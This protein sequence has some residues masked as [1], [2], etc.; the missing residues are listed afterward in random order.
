MCICMCEHC[1]QTTQRT[2]QKLLTNVQGTE[3]ILKEQ[4][5]IQNHSVQV[6]FVAKYS[7]GWSTTVQT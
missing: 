3:L 7:S 4:F 5:T 1:V 6:R 2:N